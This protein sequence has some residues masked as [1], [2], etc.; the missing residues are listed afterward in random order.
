MDCSGCGAHAIDGSTACYRCGAAVDAR[1]ARSAPATQ[2]PVIFTQVEPPQAAPPARPPRPLL[3]WVFAA[4][5]VLASVAAA[6]RLAE[7]PVYAIVGAILFGM[8]AMLIF[9]W[10]WAWWVVVVFAG[11]GAA[12]SLVGL[13]GDEAGL[14]LALLVY[15]AVLFGYMFLPTVRDYFGQ[16]PAG[17]RAPEEESGPA[18]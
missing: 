10:T 13:A 16:M 17:R 3:I 2:R 9:G 12:S 11:L 7:S 8:A 1:S 4:L 5:D 14:S 6:F 15:N 18:A